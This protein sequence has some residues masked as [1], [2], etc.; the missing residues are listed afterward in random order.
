MAVA[1]TPPCPPVSST[2]TVKSCTNEVMRI[3]DVKN[4]LKN[5]TRRTRKL[6]LKQKRSLANCWGG[7]EQRP[8]D[9][10][11]AEAGIWRDLRLQ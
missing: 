8:A 11:R 9:V 7:Y 3:L 5:A 2:V 6:D 10:V 1:P 4:G